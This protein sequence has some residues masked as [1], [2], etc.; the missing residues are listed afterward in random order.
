MIGPIGALFVRSAPTAEGSPPEALSTV[1]LQNFPH[2]N[3][4]SDVGL[5]LNGLL[6][7]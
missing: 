4:Y 1:R 2:P 7:F 5:F 3:N 6:E